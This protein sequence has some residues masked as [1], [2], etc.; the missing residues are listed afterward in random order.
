[1]LEGDTKFIVCNADEGD[2]GAYSDRYIMEERPHSLL[3]GMMIAGYITGAAFG[4]VYIRA[5]YPESIDI[6]GDAISALRDANLLGENITWF[7]I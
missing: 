4:V 1:M 2:P 5:E 7:R 3:M 6:I